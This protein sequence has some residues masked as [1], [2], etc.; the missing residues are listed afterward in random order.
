[1]NIKQKAVEK[2]TIALSC[3]N[4][5]RGALEVLNEEI[6]IHEMNIK[7]YPERQSSV[8]MKRALPK[9]EELREELRKLIVKSNK[10]LKF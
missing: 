3:L 9:L 7:T 5:L 1:M 2:F 8:R 10:E 4:F 6:N